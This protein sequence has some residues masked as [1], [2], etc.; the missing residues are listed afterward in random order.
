MKKNLFTMSLLAWVLC[1]LLPAKV[2]AQT[3]VDGLW[4]EF[5]ESAKTAAVVSSQ[6][7]SY[8]GNI[9][10]PPTVKYGGVTYSVTSI[11]FE[12]FYGCSRLT[13]IPIPASV[14]SIEYYAFSNCSGLTSVT[15]PESVTSIGN[16][17][18]RDCI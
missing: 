5:N 4:Y 7:T 14:T 2:M 13:S 17:A 11:G 15:I 6:G 1:L 10:I 8:Q 18:F 12:A 3:E 9:A 16:F